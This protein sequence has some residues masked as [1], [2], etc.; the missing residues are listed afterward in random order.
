[1]GDKVKLRLMGVEVV[2]LLA[3]DGFHCGDCDLQKDQ[4]GCIHREQFIFHLGS[5]CL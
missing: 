3:C 1:M 4:N 2:R 5:L